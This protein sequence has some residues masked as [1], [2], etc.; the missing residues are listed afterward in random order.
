[1]FKIGDAV[2]WQTRNT[3]RSNRRAQAS[4][5]RMHGTVKLVTDKAIECEYQTVAGAER[6][7]YVHQQ[8]FRQLRNGQWIPAHEPKDDPK[9]RLYL[10][11]V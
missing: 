10:T 3:G 9:G 5:L 11:K 6:Q 8:Q 1:M 4:F 2:Q 7:T